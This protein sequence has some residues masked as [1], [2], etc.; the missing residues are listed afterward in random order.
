M[1]FDF[2]GRKKESG[3]EEELSYGGRGGSYNNEPGR[4]GFSDTPVYRGNTSEREPER[5]FNAVNP[6]ENSRNIKRKKYR[7]HYDVGAIPWKPIII[8]VCII[9]A[10]AF[11]WIYR[12]A[13]TEFIGQV[14]AWIIIIAVVVLIIRFL[15][16]R[17]W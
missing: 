11:C 15:F 3:W 6:Y 10:I 12:D 7:K 13:I 8:A 14:I 9:A 1:A 2:T 17:R 4:T 5:G 16:R